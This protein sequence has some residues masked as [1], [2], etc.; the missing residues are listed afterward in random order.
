TSLDIFKILDLDEWA[1]SYKKS[2]GSLSYFYSMNISYWEQD[3]FL[4][5]ADVVVIGAGLVGLHAAWR[6]RQLH[7]SLRVVVLDAGLWPG[8][9][10]LRN[11]GFA[12]FGSP[13]ELLDDLSSRSEE[14]V[15][16]LIRRRLEGLR[17]LRTGLGDAAIGYTD[18]PSHE[19]FAASQHALAQACMDKL[20]DLNRLLREADDTRACA[21]S[22]MSG[23]AIGTRGFSQTIGIQGEGQIHPGKMM[24][25][26]QGAAR[27]AGVVIHQG[28]KVN[29]IEQKA[30]GWRIEGSEG[31]AFFTQKILLATNGFTTSLIP[32]LD[33]QPARNQVFVTNPVPG[34]LLKGNFH[35][36]AGYVYFRNVG[37]RLL[38]GGFRDLDKKGETTAAPGFSQTIQQALHQYVDTHLLPAGSWKAEH[39]WSGTLGVGETKSP[40][41]EEVKPGL[42][43]AV[44]LGG[45]GVALG[46]GLGTKA[47]EAMLG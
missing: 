8:S 13:S 35:A 22:P 44:R 1:E 5:R 38:I 14:E 36:H 9:A 27:Q 47:A 23:Q 11:A 28:W 33:V 46:A 2:M 29:V 12:C 7:P 32:E 31:K 45:M 34:L 41:M 3:I 25:A 20:D 26:L 6:M 39:R 21:F 4:K 30:G 15:I 17:Q 18:S 16:D 43:T 24:Q 40:I 42:W 37:D 10:S 19:V